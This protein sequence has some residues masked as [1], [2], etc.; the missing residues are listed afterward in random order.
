MESFS[1]SEDVLLRE[2]VWLVHLGTHCDEFFPVVGGVGNGVPGF[3]GDRSDLGWV[4]RGVDIFGNVAVTGMFGREAGGLPAALERV[5][6]VVGRD[7]KA[8]RGVVGNEIFVSTNSTYAVSKVRC[9]V[10]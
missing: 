4:L 9:T 2:R 3:A 10:K 8:R 6:V 5:F 1:F 7:R